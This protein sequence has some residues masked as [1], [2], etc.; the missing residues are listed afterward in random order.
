MIKT[1][2]MLPLCTHRELRELK[3]EVYAFPDT[4][5]D[6]KIKRLRQSNYKLEYRLRQ[7]V[8]EGAGAGRAACA[9]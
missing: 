6:A 9:R 3:K 7:R 5:M 1:H 4:Q 2:W 8:S